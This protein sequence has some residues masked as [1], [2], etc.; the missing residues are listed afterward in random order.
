MANAVKHSDAR[1]IEVRLAHH[2]HTLELSVSDD[3]HGEETRG[4]PPMAPAGH[5]GIL[6]MQERCEKLGGHFE[7]HSLAGG[8]SSVHATIP[9]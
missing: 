4:T 5:F 8:G 6:G 2:D 9:V 1:T 3:G 7:F